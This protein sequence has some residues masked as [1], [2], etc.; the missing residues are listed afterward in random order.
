M[1]VKPA[2]ALAGVAAL[3]IKRAIKCKQSSGGKA[4]AHLLN[5]MA[6]GGPAH[7]VRRIRAE[8][9]IETGRPIRL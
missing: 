7:D 2:V 6:R 8:Y 1:L 3:I 4:Q 9:G 5:H